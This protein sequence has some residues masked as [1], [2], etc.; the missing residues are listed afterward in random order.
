MAPTKTKSRKTVPASKNKTKEAADNALLDMLQSISDRLCVI[1]DKQDQVDAAQLKSHLHKMAL[2]TSDTDSSEEER[3]PIKKK[4]SGKSLRSGRI[5]TADDKVKQSIPWPHEFI[6]NPDGTPS[7]YDELS[8]SQFVHGY[9]LIMATQKPR[10]KAMMEQHLKELMT[11]EPIYGWEVV[12]NYHAIW[13]Q[14]LESERATWENSG[15]S[16]D[17][18]RT[19]V[20]NSIA[21]KQASRNAPQVILTPSPHR[22]QDVHVTPALPGTKACVA[23]QRGI[24]SQ[25]DSHGTAKHIC[26][27]CLKVAKRQC[28]HPEYECKRKEWIQSHSP[29]N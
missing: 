25:Y 27:F 21:T 15:I 20:W 14:H 26:A 29:K 22:H 12:R 28:M 6:Y 1:E 17:L 2:D 24:C 3:T 11:D 8:V 9:M 18:R 13:L 10:R 23:Y 5:L 4:N 19:H 16:S 7:K